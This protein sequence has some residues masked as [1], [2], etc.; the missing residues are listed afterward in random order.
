MLQITF[1]TKYK[2]IEI[3]VDEELWKVGHPSIIGRKPALPK[4]CS[5]LN[6]LEES[7]QKIEYQGAK[8]FALRR[9]TAKSM[10]SYELQGVLKDKE[11]SLAT[12]ELISEDFQKWG[13]LNDNEWIT[14]FVRSETARNQGPS[15]ISRKLQKK[16]IPSDLIQENLAEYKQLGSQNEG[17][18]KLIQGRYRNKDLKNWKERNKVIAAIHR[19]GFSLSAVIEVLNAYSSD[20]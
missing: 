19:K 8:R 16:G 13:L 14:S 1:Q 6:D 18:L 12:A 4:D 9:L 3:Y 15:A 20:I 10:S 5:N 2:T 11:V 17:I 7:Y